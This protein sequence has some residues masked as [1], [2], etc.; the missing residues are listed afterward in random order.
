MSRCGDCK[1]FEECK[2]YVDADETFHEVGGCSAFKRKKLTQGE[3]YALGTIAYMKK[4]F[5]KKENEK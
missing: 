4:M 5:E 3:I 2:E 1:R